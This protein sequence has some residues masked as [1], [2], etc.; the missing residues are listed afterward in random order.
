[1]NSH[2]FV[3]G[4]TV[5][6]GLLASGD[7][8][9]KSTDLHHHSPFNRGAEDELIFLDWPMSDRFPR[10]TLCDFQIRQQTNV[11]RYTVQCV[12]PINLFNEK[13]FLFVWF[14]LTF[15]G[16]STVL[17]LL[18]WTSKTTVLSAQAGLLVLFIFYNPVYLANK[19]TFL[20]QNA[21]CANQL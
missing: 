7:G 3:Y 17:D 20:Y 11:H 15:V 6:G 5:V 14:W 1:M 12:L 13:V 2:Y 10:V 21:I 8:G 4:L 9:V 19:Q 18:Y 16:L